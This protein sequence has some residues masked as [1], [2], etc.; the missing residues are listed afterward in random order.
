M[1]SRHAATWAPAQTPPA[2]RDHPDRNDAS[3]LEPVVAATA[4]RKDAVPRELHEFSESIQ[5]CARQV[6]CF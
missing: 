6:G 1:E 4:G 2:A 5:D 3:P